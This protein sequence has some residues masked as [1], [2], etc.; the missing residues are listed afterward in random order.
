MK[1]LLLA[2]V[3]FALAAGRA[4]LV[5]AR[6]A[7]LV[8]LFTSEGCSSCP[9]ADA[10]LAHLYEAQPVAGV[11]VVPL[12]L[13]V[14][15]WDRLGWKDPFSSAVYSRRQEGYSKIFGPDRV[16]TPQMVVD[17]AE[18]LVG[19]DA[20][21]AAAA[22]TKAAALPHMSVGLSAERRGA[23]VRIAVDAP[24]AP[25]AAAES[26]AVMIAVVEDGLTS[27]VTRGEN[28]GRTLAH[29]AVVRRLESIGAL[30]RDTF[31]GEG[32]WTL[33]AAWQP[34]NL[35]VVAFLQGQKTRRVYGSAQARLVR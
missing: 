8:E 5:P 18:E 12:E 13:H 33:A 30:D 27:A 11:E 1:P 23:T 21:G 24:A 17:G 9:P 28:S 7:V 20:A 15:Y 32:Q 31:S 3:L 35:R 16:Y 25:A 4:P 6:P 34:S 22:L 14:D 29:V 19:S 2:P 26:I 10:L